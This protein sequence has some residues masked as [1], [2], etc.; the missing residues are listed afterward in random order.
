[1]GASL[2]D[3]ASA[4]SKR[5]SPDFF[6]DFTGKI[7][8]A[9]YYESHPSIGATHGPAATPPGKIRISFFGSASAIALIMPLP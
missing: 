1:M 5:F 6:L 9:V 8:E 4:V 7:C 3:S 2:K